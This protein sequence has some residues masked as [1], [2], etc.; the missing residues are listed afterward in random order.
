MERYLHSPMMND[1]TVTIMLIAPVF[2]ILLSLF[3]PSDFYAPQ[4]LSA[5]ERAVLSYSR[6]VPHLYRIS[7]R[8]F[9]G[10]LKSPISLEVKTRAIQPI[11]KPQDLKAK[12]EHIQWNLTLTVIGKTKRFAIINQ[13]FLAEGDRIQGYT[14]EKISSGYVILSKKGERISLKMAK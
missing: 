5:T 8:Y 3:L 13:R 12:K 9:S 4:K 2:L 1:R 14:I 10:I 11:S 7:R 6:S